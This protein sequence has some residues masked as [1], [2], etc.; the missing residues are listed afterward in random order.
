M[1]EERHRELARMSA[2]NAR[3]LED[4]MG[5]TVYARVEVGAL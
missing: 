3:N 4:D 1:I 5:E 2:K